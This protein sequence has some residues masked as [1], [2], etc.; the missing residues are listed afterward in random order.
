[1]NEI[2]P[3]EPRDLSIGKWTI[4]Y[5]PP[6]LLGA[7]QV[8]FLIHGWTGDERSMWVFANQFPKNAWL[9]APR[10]PFPSTSNEHGGYSWVANR[11][12]GFSKYSEFMPAKK[13]FAELLDLLPTHLDVDLSKIAM[14]G[15]SQGAAFNFAFALHAQYEF[16]KM[17]ALS[18]FFPDGSEAQARKMAYCDK[19]VFI[20]HGK[21][22]ETVPIKYARQARDMLK[23]TGA[24]IEYC[25]SDVGHKL[26]ANCFTQLRSFFRD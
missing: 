9:I 22:D 24:R 18:G 6:I 21:Q 16:S 2:D 17:A 14:V 11:S 5:H 7:A 4:K 26:G 15:F 12:D 13:A 8:I 23:T 25:E 3:L 19:S 20:A 10:A 1:M